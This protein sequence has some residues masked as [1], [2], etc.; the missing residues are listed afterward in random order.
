MKP[1]DLIKRRRYGWLA[2][3]LERT[4]NT[5]VGDFITFAHADTGE[6]DAASAFLFEVVSESR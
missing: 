6:I 3:V 2:V 1:G 5:D 4:K